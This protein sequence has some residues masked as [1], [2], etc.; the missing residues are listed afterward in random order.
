[1]GMETWKSWCKTTVFSMKCS[2]CYNPARPG[3]RTCH[4]CHAL[5]MRRW[6]IKQR[7]LLQDL[8]KAVSRLERVIA[9][10]TA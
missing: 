5:Y 1:M 6:R 8:R 2:T 7:L 10:K 9:S 4:D 3:Q